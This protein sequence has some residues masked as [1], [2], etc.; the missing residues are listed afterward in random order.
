MSLIIGINI[1]N[2]AKQKIKT[3]LKCIR[4]K[5][6]GYKWVDED[7]YHIKILTFQESMQQE[8]IKEKLNSLLYDQEQFYLYSQGVSLSIRH[9]IK[10][11]IEFI[12]EKKLGK[13]AE[14]IE[15]QFDDSFEKGRKYVPHLDIATY[16]IPSKQQYLLLKKKLKNTDIS[17]SFLVSELVLFESLHEKGKN[18][19]K[20]ISTFSLYKSTT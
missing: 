6:E 16:K 3:Q 17:L 2:S 11:F 10:I 12:K 14:N 9:K 1:P 18:I 5:Y 19:L 8:K 13:L 20:V 7:L 15:K 4:E